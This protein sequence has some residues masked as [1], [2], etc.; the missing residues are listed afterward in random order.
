MLGPLLI[1]HML[2]DVLPPGAPALDLGASVG[3]LPLWALVLWVSTVCGRGSHSFT[4]Q[5]NVSAFHGNGGAFRG[6]AGGV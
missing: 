3:F 6:C 1:M 5:L 2:R 4:V